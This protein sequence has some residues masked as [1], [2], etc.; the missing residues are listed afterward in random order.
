MRT[1]QIIIA[2]DDHWYSEFLEYH[3]TLL[4]K[5]QITKVKTGTELFKHLKNKPDLITLDY[6]LPDFKGDDV[7]NRIKMESPKT[8]VVLVSGQNDIETAL[9]LI[10]NGAF[11]YIVKNEDAKNRLHTVLNNL[12][13]QKKLQSRIEEL[14]DQVNLKYDLSKSIIGDSKVIKSVFK[15]IDKAINSSINISITGETGTGKEVVAKAIH[16]NSTRAKEPFVAINLSA[17]PDTL[18]ESELFGYVK[19]AFTGAEKNK[20]GKFEEAKSGTIFLDEIGE[21]SLSSQVKILRVLQ[22]RKITRLGSNESRNIDCRIICATHQD[23]TALVNKGQFREDLYYRLIGLPIHLPKLIDR[24]NDVILLA[25][26][27]TELYCKENKLT[28]KSINQKSIEKLMAYNFPGNVRELKSIMDLA[29]VMSDDDTITVDNIIFNQ[30]RSLDDIVESNMTLKE[31][32]EKI[33]LRL[34][35]NN[36]NNVFKVAQKLNI[37]KSTIYRLLNENKREIELN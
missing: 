33:I 37:G 32:N 13:K 34:L 9:K 10:Q 8:D 4:H 6:N 2:E 26:Y 3:L 1:L 27:F 16:F 7:L 22:E 11:D 5:H 14:E 29:C 12:T 35:D 24:E 36:N 20:A 28:C 18:I 25:K 31:I 19:G 15:Y 17:I 30:A 21:I 23:L